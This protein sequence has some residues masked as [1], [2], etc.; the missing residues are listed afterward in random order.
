MGYIELSFSNGNFNGTIFN[1]N[2]DFFNIL[3]GGTFKMD[4]E[5]LYCDTRLGC[6]FIH[7]ERKT[8]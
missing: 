5:L 8:Q 4:L 1:I 6:A 2:A 3:F 7:Y